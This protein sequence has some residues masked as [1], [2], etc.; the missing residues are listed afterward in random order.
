MR[1]IFLQDQIRVHTQTGN[2]YNRQALSDGSNT[3]E[4]VILEDFVDQIILKL[5]AST[6]GFTGYMYDDISDTYF[7]Q[8]REYMPE[9]GR[10][11]GRDLLKGEAEIPRSLNEYVYCHNKPIGSVDYDGMKAKTVDDYIKAGA[12]GAIRSSVNKVAIDKAN[13][14]ATKSVTK[15]ALAQKVAANKGYSRVTKH[16]VK[17]SKAIKKLQTVRSRLHHNYLSLVAALPQ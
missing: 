2:S 17:N 1:N 7:A 8:A 14:E 10:F 9:V 12:D 16:V 11:A 3:F 6:L 13:K 4:H 15:K 5:K